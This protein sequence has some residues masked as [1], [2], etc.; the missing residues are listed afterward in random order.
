MDDLLPME[1]RWITRM[2]MD[3]MANGS[4]A[5]VG[6]GCPCVEQVF[7]ERESD[8]AAWAPFVAWL[9]LSVCLIL[10]FRMS[11]LWDLLLN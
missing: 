2:S 7:R 5:S 1:Q 4:A 6:T 3:T 11:A 9:G 10:P 8:I